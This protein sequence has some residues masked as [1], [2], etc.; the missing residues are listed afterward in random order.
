MNKA[1]T[2]VV[3]IGGGTAGW[4][5]AGFLAKRHALSS[6]NPLTVTLIESPTIPSIGVGEGTWPSMRATLEKIGISETDFLRHCHAAFKQGTKFV[7]WRTQAEGD[8]YYHPFSPPVAA[9]KIDPQAYL[10][11]IR[12]SHKP[13]FADAVNFQQSLCEAGL[14]PKLISTPEYKAVANYAYHLDA[15]RFAELLRTHCVERLGVRHLLDE[16]GTIAQDADGHITTVATTAHGIIAGDLFVDCTGFR[17]LLIDKT[18]QVPFIDK[19]DTLFVDHALA[20]QLPYAEADQ[21]VACQT[22]ST[23][24]RAGWIWDIGLSNR[25]GIGYVYSSAHTSHDEAENTLRQYV[26]V[27]ADIS[28]RRIAFQSGYRARPWEKN[29][30]AIGLS[31][32]FLEPLEASALMLVELS[33]EMLSER[34]PR[35]RELM[36]VIARQFNEQFLY[37]WERIIEFLKLHYVLSQRQGEDF[38]ADNRKPASI[39]ARLQENLALWRYHAPSKYDFFSRDEVFSWPSYVYVLYG[40]NGKH[41]DPEVVT[42]DEDADARVQQEFAAN[43]RLKQR[44]LAELP[45]HRELLNK[46]QQYGFQRI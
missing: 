31:A 5:T 7:N 11:Q 18:L 32:G 8:F 42:A 37:R 2:S 25:R 21:A 39:P 34:I 12:A 3:I 36:P 46:V 10:R 35:N 29:C 23:A 19:T 43:E 38:W 45:S 15:A 26:G 17:G 1:I 33:A 44:L 40:M 20:V 30:V 4:I 22:I 13:D 16:V 14:A 41:G 24:Q 27:Q 9:G 6:A 28:P